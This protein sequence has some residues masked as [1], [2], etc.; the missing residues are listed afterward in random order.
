[1]TDTESQRNWM[2]TLVVAAGVVIVGAFLFLWVLSW[3]S[4]IVWFLVKLAVFALVIFLIV[5]LVTSKR[6]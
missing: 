6:R 3:L 5:R 2:M 4:G 1:V